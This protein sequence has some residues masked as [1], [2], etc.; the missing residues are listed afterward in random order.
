MFYQTATKQSEESRGIA[1]FNAESAKGYTPNLIVL[2]KD[3]PNSW[4]AF[5]VV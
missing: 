1:F 2:Y 3:R 5:L 4:Q